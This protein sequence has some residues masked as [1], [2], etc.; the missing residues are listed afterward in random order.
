[1]VTRSGRF[2]G[3]TGD[4]DGGAEEAG[5]F[6]GLNKVVRHGDV[7]GGHTGDINDDDFGAVGTNAT[8]ELFG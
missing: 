1:M 4:D 8:Q 2:L 7:H 6:D 3:E 5:S